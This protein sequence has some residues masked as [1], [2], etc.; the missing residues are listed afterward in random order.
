MA[1]AS[2]ICFIENNKGAFVT[3]TPTVTELSTL[4]TA[5]KLLPPDEVI[6]NNPISLVKYKVHG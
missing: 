5:G 3:A 6:I 4:E 1:T 2:I